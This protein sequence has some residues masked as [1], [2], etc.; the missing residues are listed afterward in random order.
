MLT[1]A[2]ESHLG[3]YVYQ[4]GGPA[5]GIFQM[6][7]AT[8]IDI[9]DNYLRY[10]EGLRDELLY[11]CAADP[12]RDL[13]GNIPYQIL[14]ARFHYLRVK[15]PLPKAEDSK[16]LAE[17]WKKYYNTTL[18]KGTVEKAIEEYKKYVQE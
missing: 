2:V 14:M 11:F 5:R 15:E 10:Q 3:H 9:Y 7:P 13:L 4:I 1:A 18:G 17:Y 6:E 8:A 12:E 16:G